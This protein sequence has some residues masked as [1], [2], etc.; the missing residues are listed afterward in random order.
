[1]AGSEERSSQQPLGECLDAA[2]KVAL[3]AGKIIREALRIEKRVQTKSSAADLVTETDRL[4]ENLI[5]STLSEKFPSHRFIGE[6]SVADGEKCFLTDDPTWIIDPIDGTCNFVHGAPVVAV[7]IGLSVK[8]ELELGVIYSCVEE[9]LYTGRKGHGAFCNGQKLQASNQ[10]DLSKALILT[11]LGSIRDPVAV[12]K[13][14]NNME[15]L[16]KVPAHGIR[17]IGSAALDLCHVA[18]GDVDAFYQFGLHCWDMAAAAVIVREA[19]GIMMDTTGESLDLM[20]RRVVAA[21][22]SEMA[23]KICKEL[24]PVVYERDD[25]TESTSN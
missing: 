24:Q 12:K 4:V 21:G 5:I 14:F 16:L 8:K 1:M 17:I 11:E 18:A 19:G 25:S 10:T 20:S 6:E 22:T 9:K 23:H 15:R 3:E 13:L 7:S 2:V